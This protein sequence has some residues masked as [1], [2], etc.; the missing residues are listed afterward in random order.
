MKKLLLLLTVLA[1]VAQP[2]P[3][4][5]QQRVVTIASTLQTTG[6]ID[7][8]NDTVTLS[9][10]SGQ[11]YAS[12]GIE[13]TGTFVATIEIRCAVRQRSTPADYTYQAVRITPYNSTT[14]ATSLTATG[15]WNANI[16]GCSRVIAF[17][18]AYTS[19]AAIVTL[20]A[21]SLG[22]AGGA[23]GG[24]TIGTVDQ[25]TSPWIVGDG[26]GALNVIVDSGVITTVSAVTA[27]TNAVTVTDGAGALNVICDSGCAGGATDADDA[28]I[29]AGQTNANSNALGMVYN[30][31]AWV[32]N[33]IGTAGSASAQVWTVQGVASMTALTVSDG[34]GALN[35]ICDSGCSGGVQYTQ[36]AALTVAT[37]VGGM[38]MGRASAAAPTDVTADNDAV[39]PWY[40]RS[41]A[42]VVQSTFAG[43]LATTGNGV[44]GTGVQR[45]TIASDSTGSFLGTLAHN[46]AAAATNRLATL[47]AVVENSAPSLTDGRNAALSLTT[48]GAMRVMITNSAGSASTL[49]SD[50]TIGT[51]TYTEATSTAPGLFV[52]NDTPDSLVN[53]TNEVT[54]AGVNANGAV[55]MSEIDPCSSEA[56]TTDPISLTTDTVIIAAT[57]SKKNYICALV[58]VAGAAEVVSI[59]EG[60]GSTCATS[61]AALLGSTTDA[62]GA[63]FAANGGVSGIGGNA[64]IIAGKTA[65]VDTCLNVSGSSRVSGFVTWVQR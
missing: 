61:E 22:G 42:V 27:I 38:A 33:T 23:G 31:S 48:G 4:A 40:L 2:I 46:G 29:A 56:K 20:N 60:T 41:G 32:R 18:T 14:A 63:S 5:A 7:G 43:V 57:A 53:T 19:G 34:A 17:R 45:V 50:A 21:A 11:A 26:A 15:T 37:T 59:T 47:P 1:L 51:T 52:R 9:I 39:M 36:D 49:A 25:G 54:V 3:V 10:P 24:G 8:T 65:N 44:S 58:V 64:T 62:N 30:G 35:V 55:W 6:T 12:L 13:V 28:S 16:A